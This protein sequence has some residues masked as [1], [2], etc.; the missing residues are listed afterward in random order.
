[1]SPHP[2]VLRSR[3]AT[4]IETELSCVQ[5]PRI[6]IIPHE[7]SGRGKSLLVR[8]SRNMQKYADDSGRS[9]LLN[10]KYYYYFA[11]RRLSMVSNQ[12]DPSDP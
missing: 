8:K 3:L 7:K 1:M 9:G 11:H 2:K 10:G 4:D 6:A 5:K 12:S